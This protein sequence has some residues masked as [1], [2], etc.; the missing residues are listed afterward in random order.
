MTADNKDHETDGPCEGDDA[1]ARAE[2]ARKGS[3]FLNTAQ[4][5]HYLGISKRTLEEMRERGEGPSCR[6]HGRQ[7]RYHITDVDAWSRTNTSDVGSSRRSDDQP[8]V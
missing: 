6:K 1:C 5:A 8:Q 3:P 2:I 7:V 4:A